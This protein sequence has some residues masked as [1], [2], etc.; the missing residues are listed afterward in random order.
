MMSQIL[1]S[2]N[3]NSGA[4]QA[5]MVIILV[6]ITAL[7]AWDTKRIANISTKQLDLYTRPLVVVGESIGVTV[8]FD[9]VN[10]QLP[11]DL[12]DWVRFVYT[13]KNIGNIP[14]KYN[15]Y[16]EFNEHTSKSEHEAILYPGQILTHRTE[17]YSIQP[18]DPKKIKGIASIKVVYWSLDTPTEKHF[19]SRKFEIKEN[20]EGYDILQDE[21]GPIRKI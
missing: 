4:V 1:D 11:A 14:V 16:T 5:I 7:Y 2:L 21:A 17:T 13:I 20:A 6:I 15:G 9:T 8:Q 10:P 3:K 18:T 19:F 12:T